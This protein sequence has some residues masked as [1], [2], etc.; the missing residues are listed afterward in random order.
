LRLARTLWAGLI[1]AL[2]ACR[3]PS[4]APAPAAAAL[5]E[6]APPSSLVAELSLGNPK[7]TWRRLRVLGGDRAQALPSSLPVLLA[8]SLSL[9]PAAAGGLDEAVPMVGVILSR[10]DRAE[11]DVVLGMHVVS[12]AELVASLSLG[13]GAKFRRVE[14]GPRVVRLVSAPGAPE[15]DGALGVSGN[16]LL[17]ST[18]V[19]SLKDAARFVAEKV[20]KRARSEPGLTLTAG[21][22]VLGGQLARRLR[23]AWH[24][25]RARLSAQDLAARQAKGRAPDFADPAVLLSGA[26]STVESWLSVLE[27]SRELSLSLSP[28][29]DRLRAELRLTPAEEGAARALQRDLVVGSNAPLF[30][31]P[32]GARAGLLLRGDARPGEGGLG[33]GLGSLFGDRL[34]A[35]QATRL[36]RALD[37]FAKSRRG[38]TVLGLVP[39]PAPALVIRCELS[40]AVAFSQSLSELLALI[41]LPAVTAWLSGTLGRPSVERSKTKAGAERARVRFLPSG[42]RA[43]ALPKSLSLTWQ[44]RGDVGV[45][46]LSPEG[47]LEPSA[48][49]QGAR[50]GERAWLAR[51][52][53]G[54]LEQTALALYLD[55]RL[56][57]PGGP[58][59]APL[60]LTFGRKDEQTALLLELS[61]PALSALARRF[62]LDR[63][64]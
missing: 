63:S 42:P 37:A 22:S 11:P 53:A 24:A 16:Y 38:A 3:S 55:A 27:S 36:N 4:D 2:V 51:D 56:L 10:P 18:S 5:P 28:E 62:A 33:A 61:A 19:D 15:F 9:P 39:A 58:D 13:D 14:L 25:E 26:D 43:L 54:P 41:E 12:G 59:E 40:D 57:A 8:T 50:L 21:Q 47:S 32:A 23:D 6:A 30:E 49:E 7:E 29:P 60:W 45:I 17:L 31:L 44:A 46:V 35:P 20:S 48:F 1:L 64:P 52:P 34:S